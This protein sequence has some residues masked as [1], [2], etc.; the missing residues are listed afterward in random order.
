M[1]L[2]LFLLYLLL[3]VSTIVMCK[4]TNKLPKRS[5]LLSSQLNQK[6]YV[7]NDGLDQ[8]P[9]KNQVGE[10]MGDL[11]MGMLTKDDPETHAKIKLERDERLKK[12]KREK[13]LIIE[14]VKILQG[15]LL[16]L[17]RYLIEQDAFSQANDIINHI[18]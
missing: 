10:L 4:C 13:D 17:K 1:K 3:A 9:N 14:E 2:K 16:M 11:M 18:R 12:A 15:K 6:L 5:T 7:N 8:I